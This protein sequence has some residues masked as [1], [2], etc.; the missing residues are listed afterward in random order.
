[1]LEKYKNKIICGDCLEIMKNIPDKSVEL[2][3]TDP[4]YQPPA[5]YYD[6]RK[7]FPKTLSDFGLLDSFFSQFFQEL[8]RILSDK[9]R[10]YVFCNETSYPIFF[11]KC[12][13]LFRKVRCLVW[14]KKTAFSGYTWRHQYELIL[15]GE[16]ENAP[17]IRTGDGDILRFGVVKVDR[18]NHPAEKPIDLLEKIISKHQ[19]ELVFD[20]FMGVGSTIIAAKNCGKDY[21]G[22]EISSE[23]IKIAKERLRQEIL[24]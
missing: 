11:V 9:A 15:L 22:I 6:T 24:L 13:P 21:L 20:P 3:I 18:R 17:I 16:K 12:Y 14:D 19:E 23:Y 7:N 4:P 10:I 5:K 8:N 2:V 1:M